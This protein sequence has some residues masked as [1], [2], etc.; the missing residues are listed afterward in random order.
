MA[1]TRNENG[2][3][4]PL[5]PEEETAR[6]AEEQAWADARPARAMEKIRNHRNGLLSTTDWTANSDVTMSDAMKT[7]RQMLR[8]IPAS[9]TV[10][11]DVDWGTKP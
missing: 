4:I 2:V 8:D 5:T 7:Y 6:D 10:Y 9:N 1:R 11:D 3:D